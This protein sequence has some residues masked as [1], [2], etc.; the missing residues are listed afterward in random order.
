MS[1]HK[2]TPTPSLIRHDSSSNA[3]Q[4]SPALTITNC[5]DF[6]K[7]VQGTSDASVRCRMCSG[8]YE[9]PVKLSCKHLLCLGCVKVLVGQEQLKRSS[10]YLQQYE[11]SCKEDYRRTPPFPT[12][13]CTSLML[14]KLAQSQK[15]EKTSSPPP[16]V[17]EMD[18]SAFEIACP[19]CTSM[20]YIPYESINDVESHLGGVDEDMKN[21]VVSYNEN[22]AKG[23]MCANCEQQ[24]ASCKCEQCNHFMCD[25]C[26]QMIHNQKLLANHKKVDIKLAKNFG[27]CEEHNRELDLICLT[28]NVA[29]CYL[30]TMSSGMH[31]MHNFVSIPDHATTCR[32]L[33]KEQLGAECSHLNSELQG[34]EV[35]ISQSHESI[36]NQY[37]TTKSLIEDSFSALEERVAQK[38]MELLQEVEDHF[39]NPANAVED[40]LKAVHNLKKYLEYLQ[41]V[42]SDTVDNGDEMSVIQSR[43]ILGKTI[44]ATLLGESQ[45]QNITVKE[46]TFD[47]QQLDMIGDLISQLSFDSNIHQPDD[48][49]DS[50]R[51]VSISCLSKKKRVSIDPLAMTL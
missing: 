8:Y 37:K 20:T 5:V 6:N 40:K 25:Y 15:K 46:L 27:T 33:M 22:K 45:M 28:D 34:Y 23:T 11:E 1:S 2:N 24:Y 14:S 9:D 32:L 21:L 17:V 19:Q 29:M 47:A 3:V 39:V 51:S 43:P 13:L 10:K 35:Q 41:D 31:H 38:K 26:F 4:F 12:T 30:C 36:Q 16:A 42:I 7:E 50:A 49:Q 48:K 18:K 44:E